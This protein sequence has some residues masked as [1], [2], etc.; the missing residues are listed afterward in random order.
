MSKKFASFL[1][2]YSFIPVFLFGQYDR[3]DS[4]SALSSEKPVTDYFDSVDDKSFYQRQ[5]IHGMKREINEYSERLHN[6]QSRFDEIFYGLSRGNSFNKPFNTNVTPSRP[7]KSDLYEPSVQSTYAPPTSRGALPDVNI[8]EPLFSSPPS[9]SSDLF[10][11]EVQNPVNQLAF[12]VEA[13]GSYTK[14][15]KTKSLFNPEDHKSPGAWGKYFIL[16]PG[17]AIPYKIH[18]P[19]VPIQNKETYRR[20]DPGVSILVSGGFEKNNFRFGLGGLYK[21][22]RHHETSYEFNTAYP[23]PSHRKYFKNSAESFAGFLDL[24]YEFQVW[25]KLGAYIGAGLG[26]Y[27]SII[28]DPRERK[29]HGFFATG[30]IGVAYNFNEMIALRL[31][32]RYLHEEEVPAHVA[33]LGLGFEF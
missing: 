28:E 4:Y 32:Y 12:Q 20:Y 27:L 3:G 6:L 16:T 23:G 24:G 8:D 15:G 33:E 21:K 19:S 2:A 7:P 26:Y 14:D 22:H 29:D 25:G 30:N 11:P 31:G 13:P 9:D 1:T 5:R 17:Y 10:E 18:K